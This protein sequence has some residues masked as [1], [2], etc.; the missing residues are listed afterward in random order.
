MRRILWLL[1]ML[2]PLA[3]NDGCNGRFIPSGLS[4][5]GAIPV[6]GCPVAEGQALEEVCRDPLCKD[7]YRC[8]EQ[9]WTPIGVC[10][11]FVTA[12]AGRDGSTLDAA[13]ESGIVA[14]AAFRDARNDEPGPAGRC[15]ELQAPD[16]SFSFAMSCASRDCCGCE[17]LFEC[18]GET[19]TL[20]GSC[21]NGLI[22][23][24]K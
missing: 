8:V 20:A 6:N 10:T 13:R 3:C 23:R 22:T 2:L 19:W 16:C 12:D 9:K 1:P 5:C 7:G 18:Q 4:P 24:R 15:K 14:D 21:D 17:D 11:G